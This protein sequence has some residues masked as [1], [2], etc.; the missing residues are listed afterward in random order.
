MAGAQPVDELYTEI[1][2]YVQS[3]RQRNS[4]TVKEYVDREELVWDRLRDAI[5]VPNGSDPETDVGPLH[6]QLRGFL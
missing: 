4:E 6:A 1:N 2:F 3:F 5:R